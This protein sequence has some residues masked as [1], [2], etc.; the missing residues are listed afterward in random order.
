MIVKFSA[1]IKSASLKLN[2]IGRGA[3]SRETLSAIGDRVLRHV[4]NQFDTNGGGQW[5]RLSPNTVAKK[6]HSAPLQETGAL[7]NSWRKR[8]NTGYSVTVYSNDRKA[9]FHQYGTAPHFI[10]PKNAKSLRFVTAGGV[11]F[12]RGVNHPGNQARPML[13]EKDHAK[14]ISEVAALVNARI[15]VAVK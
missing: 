13:P 5:K 11:R 7:R 6:G 2:A 14:L 8:V 15:S 12:S 10:A 1:D 3:S 4:D 9:P